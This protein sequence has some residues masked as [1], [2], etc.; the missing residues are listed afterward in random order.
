M[1]IVCDVCTVK[2][3]CWWGQSW[4]QSW[5]SQGARMTMTVMLS[6]LPFL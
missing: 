3:W 1:L 5:G 2:G 6:K 4:G